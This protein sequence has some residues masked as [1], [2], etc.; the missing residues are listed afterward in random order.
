MIAG[1]DNSVLDPGY[2][3]DTL[4]VSE[5]ARYRVVTINADHI[6]ELTREPRTSEQLELTPFPDLPLMLTPRQPREYV[7][8][9][10]SGIA[11]WSGRIKGVGSSSVSLVISPDGS[12]RGTIFGGGLALGIK[13]TTSLPYHVITQLD[14]DFR[15]GRQSD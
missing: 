13:P 15:S 12:V 2:L 1:A 10:R 7:E 8:G 5:F 6:R 4:K 9:W 11:V 3:G 14:P